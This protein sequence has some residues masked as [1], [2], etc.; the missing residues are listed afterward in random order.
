LNQQQVFGMSVALKPFA[1]LFRVRG[2]ASETI[3]ALMA[4]P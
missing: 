4:I 3:K 2:E 1:A